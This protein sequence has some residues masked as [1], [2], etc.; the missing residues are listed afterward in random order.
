M[1]IK[2]D[3]KKYIL[4]PT[5]LIDNSAVTFAFTLASDTTVSTNIT[6]DPTAI[7]TRNAG[8]ST[9]LTVTITYAVGGQTVTDTTTY[10]ATVPAGTGAATWVKN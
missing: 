7:I 4:R 8:G 3:F 9:I 1:F 2:M 6:S 10:T 5:N